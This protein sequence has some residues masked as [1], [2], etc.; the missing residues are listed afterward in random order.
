VSTDTTPG[1]HLHVI[2]IHSHVIAGDT[3]RFPLN[4]MGGKQSDWSRERPVDGEAMLKAMANAGVGQS[5][6]VQASTCYGHD[7]RYVAAC[8][9]AHPAVFGGVFSV[10]MAAEDAVANIQR[11]MKLGMSGARVFVA[12]HTASDDSVRLDDPRSTPAWN[13]LVSDRIPVSVQL[14]TDKLD[15]LVNLLERHPEAVV[16]L[17]HCARPEL[18][19]GAP[20]AQAAS[21]FALARYPNLNLKLTTHN[22]REAALGLATP[23]SFVQALVERFGAQRIAWGSNFPASPGG[24][25]LQ[26][27]QALEATATLEPAQRAHIFSGTSLRLYPALHRVAS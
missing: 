14:R 7:N 18:G 25:R 20:Y 2:D 8:V 23:A 6:L 15:Q 21:L 5:V 3:A 11:W 17:D 26:L 16:V 22:L 12:G 27:Q 24:L 9:Q 10:D 13:H 1:H 4:P 19:D